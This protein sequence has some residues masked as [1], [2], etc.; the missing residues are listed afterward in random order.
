MCGALAACGEPDASPT[1]V[2]VEG[3]RL[4][5]D[6]KT[7]R[8]WEAGFG[9]GL[10][11]VRVKVL[12][13]EKGVCSFDYKWEVEGAGNYTVHRV[14]VPV[15]SGPVV[16]EAAKPDGEGEHHWSYVYTSFTAGQAQLLRHMSFGWFERP[17]GDGF[18]SYY[19]FRTG[20]KAP[21]IAPGD[22]ITL[23]FLV[24]SDQEFDK[25]AASS[26]WQ[27]E[28]SRTVTTQIGKGGSW[29]WVQAVAEEMTPYEIRR[30]RV[31][32]ELAGP[33]KDWGPG[34][35]EAATLYAEMQL[36]EVERE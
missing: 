5:F 35:E 16:I 36:V 1:D 21:P 26:G 18:A 13:R 32:M 29:L 12:G 14:R 23:R 33:A 9:W 15:D 3:S 7:C 8:E 2:L 20:D 25:P 24:F 31:P 30:V 27:S 6:P 34:V 19:R 4:S 11:S 22:K 28:W 17:V 10:G